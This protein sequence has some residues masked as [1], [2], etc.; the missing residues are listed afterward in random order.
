[1]QNAYSVAGHWA[2]DYD[3]QALQDWAESLRAKL[4]SPQVSLGLTF[5][6][7]KFFPQAAQILE[8]LRVHARIPLLAGCS[9]PGL[10]VG[11][12]EVEEKAGLSLGLYA[13]PGADLR[14]FH[15]TQAQVEEM[16]DPINWT[17]RT[18]VSPEQ[19][20]GWLVFADP[21]HMDCE[22]WLKG[23]NEAYPSRPVLGGLA[24]GISENLLTQV[25]LNGEVHE[26]GGVAQVG[27]LWH[28]TLLLCE[29]VRSRQTQYRRAGRKPQ[30][31]GAIRSPI[32]RERGLGAYSTATSPRDR[33][34]C[35]AS[36]R[37]FRPILA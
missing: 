11:D 20:N 35:T 18:G 9:S 14:G 31:S 3:E 21:F 34:Q 32:W 33:A 16:T 4:E 13:L 22:G 5:L 28:K 15:F 1:M 27:Q 8:L 37:V 30:G 17:S 19:T 26:E 2:G 24:S 7:P 6:S 36:P 12:Q 10:I 29:S 23:W 25:Y